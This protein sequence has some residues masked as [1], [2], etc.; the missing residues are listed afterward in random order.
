MFKLWTGEDYLEFGLSHSGFWVTQERDECGSKSVFLV[1]VLRA[2]TVGQL[3]H[4]VV[5]RQMGVCFPET[6]RTDVAERKTMQWGSIYFTFPI[7][8]FT[9]LD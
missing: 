8:H 3:D 9:A 4:A 1:V 6:P 7:T 2:V 5:V